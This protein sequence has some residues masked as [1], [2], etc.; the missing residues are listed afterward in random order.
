MGDCYRGEKMAA[1]ALTRCKGGIL[2]RCVPRATEGWP[3]AAWCTSRRGHRCGGD[4]AR[5]VGE[6]GV[7]WVSIRRSAGDACIQTMI[8]SGVAL[9]AEALA[10]GHGR[11]QRPSVAR[12]G[13]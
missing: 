4:R 6:G 3:G 1:V 7:G 2:S 13:T 5:V 11:G 10:R 9:S 8:L 12:R